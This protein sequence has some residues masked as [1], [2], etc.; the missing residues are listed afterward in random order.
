MKYLIINADDFGLSEPTNEGIIKGYKEGVITSTTIM[1][2]MPAFK[3]AVKLVKRNRGL[4][5][6]VHLNLTQ[7][8]PL[9]GGSSFEKSSL[10]KLLMGR[11][12][13]RFIEKELREQISWVKSS[14]INITHLDGHK[15][16]HVFP[17]VKKVVLKL[18]KEFGIN[19]V[20][21]PYEGYSDISS[22]FTKENLKR[23]VI[24]YYARSA[25]KLWGRHGLCCPNFFFGSL[26]TGDMNSLNLMRILSSLKWGVNEIMVHPGEYDANLESNLKGSRKIELDALTDMRIK[27][28]VSKL[29]IQLVNFG[30]LNGIR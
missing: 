27:G 9:S 15:H 16:V 19:Y 6:G 12:G 30:D 29:N 22:S 28:F 3:D 11:V 2:N 10:Q 5:V 26:Y 18:A 17:E 23:H 21:V 20:R 8:R 24:N 25:R 14:G 7:G 1:A 13:T 4:G